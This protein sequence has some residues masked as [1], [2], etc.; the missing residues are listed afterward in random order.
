MDLYELGKIAGNVALLLYIITLLPGI[1]A[2]LGIQNKWFSLLRLYRRKIGIIMFLTAGAHVICTKLIFIQKLS[3]LLPQGTFEIMGM[4]AIECLL[5]LFLTSNNFSIKKLRIW[6]FR[7]Q[8][9][10]YFALFFIF[11]H[12]ALIKLS[13]WSVLMGVTVVLQLT[14]F[15]VAYKKTHSFISGRPI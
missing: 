7:I 13:V 2:R 14:S 1:G 9:L 12:V 11:L 8:R 4:L 3:D 15:F 10:T 5:L 6:W